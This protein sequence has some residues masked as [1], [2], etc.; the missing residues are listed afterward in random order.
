M[1]DR[2][3]SHSTGTIYQ[4]ALRSP[5]EEVLL[6]INRVVAFNGPN[7]KETLFRPTNHTWIKKKKR[8]EIQK[9]IGNLIEQNLFIYLQ[10]IFFLQ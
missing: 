5:A 3:P 7:L 1:T 9:T 10:P 6:G 8:R 4:L 2:K